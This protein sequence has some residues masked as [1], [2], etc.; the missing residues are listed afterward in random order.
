MRRQQPI[1]LAAA[2]SDLRRLPTGRYAARQ[3]AKPT[4]RCRS[5]DR[6]RDIGLRMDSESP[7][8]G[9]A[10][11]G[12]FGLKSREIRGG[13]SGRCR[14][15]SNQPCAA[16]WPRRVFQDSMR[17]RLAVA[18]W[19]RAARSRSW[20]SGLRWVAARVPERRRTLSRPVWRLFPDTD[21]PCIERSVASAGWPSAPG[22]VTSQSGLRAKRPAS[23]QLWRNGQA[24]PGHMPS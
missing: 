2:A 14:A 5:P 16:S 18:A 3:H 23:Q 12:P 17:G 20:A 10:H 8:A 22:R 6:Q 19:P 7:G 21:H 15:G 13:R 1:P 9:N 11:Q 4:A 24:W